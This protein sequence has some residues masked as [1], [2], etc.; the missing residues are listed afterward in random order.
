MIEPD[1][2]EE[3]ADPGPH[4][5]GELPGPYGHTITLLLEKGRDTT[6]QL[7]LQLVHHRVHRHDHHGGDRGALVHHSRGHVNQPQSR[8]PERQNHL[9]HR[10]DRHLKHVGN[11]RTWRGDRFHIHVIAK[12]SLHTEDEI[13]RNIELAQETVLGR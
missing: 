6:L 1:D 11:T 9:A 13:S 2:P 7:D 8:G 10:H 12:K 3:E 4:E 5:N